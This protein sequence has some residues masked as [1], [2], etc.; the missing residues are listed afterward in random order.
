VTDLVDLL[1]PLFAQ[2]FTLWGAPVTRLELVAFVLA[3]AMVMFNIRV[4]PTGWPLAIVS[5]LLYFALFWDSRLYGEAGLQ[6]FFALVA[7]WGWWQ[8]LR[9]TQHDGSA[10]RVRSLGARGRWA[11]LAMLGAAWPATG[12]FLATATDTDVPWWDAFPTAASVLGQWLLGRK[13]IETWPTWVV[14]NVTSVALFASKGLWLTS[15]L[16]TL[17]VALSFLGW[18]E[19]SR[20]ARRAA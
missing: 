12:L 1:Q 3:L 19:W 5:S 7:G 17:F 18:R 16:Y 2:A 10:L 14:V 11:A 20:R 9:G 4:N 6:I 13:Y 15:L 8:W